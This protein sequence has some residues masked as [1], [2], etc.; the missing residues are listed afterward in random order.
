MDA[1]VIDTA[2]GHSANVV[3]TL[4]AV[5]AQFPQI[6]VL[7]GNIATAEAAEYLIANG[8]DGIK[9]GI[10]PGSICTT[11]IVAGVG[12]PQLSAIF[13]CSKVAAKYGVPVIGDGGL[14]YSGDVV[15][16]IAA[17]AD[18]VM[19]GSMLAGTEESPGETIIYN[20]RKFKAY[21][22]MGSIEAMQAGSKDRY[23]QSATCD[24]SKF[25]PEGIVAR[26]PYKGTLAETI[27][28]ASSAVSAPEWATAVRRISRLSTTLASCASPLL[29]VIENHPHDVTITKEAPNYSRAE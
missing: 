4:K 18:C 9:V 14:R 25:V 7:V 19:M 16:A 17:G 8:A 11:R 6:D 12:V 27:Y 20:G 1:V 13:N 24:S 3:N 15:K 5:K 29:G 23:F 10:G 28:Q 21:R 22:G 26:V 2:H